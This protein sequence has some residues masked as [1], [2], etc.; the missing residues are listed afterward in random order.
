MP[1]ISNQS[2][3]NRTKQPFQSEVKKASWFPF[4]IET[5]ELNCL[6]AGNVHCE[7]CYEQRGEVTFGKR[8]FNWY[9]RMLVSI[10]RELCPVDYLTWSKRSACGKCF[11]ILKIPVNIVLKFT[12]PVVIRW[13]QPL[14]ALHCVTSPLFF[15]FVIG[16]GNYYIYEVIPIWALFFGI[17]VVLMIGVLVTTKWDEP[18]RYHMVFAVMG[19]IS[20]IIWVY[21]IANEIVGLLIALG[22]VF[23]ISD[24]ILGLTVLAWGNSINDVVSDVTIAREGYPEMGISACFGGPLFNLLMGLGVSFTTAIYHSQTKVFEVI[25]E[26]TTKIL[27]SFLFASLISS[28]V[29]VPCVKFD[30]KRWY[31]L[32]L[33]SLYAIFLVVI[34]LN[35]C[36]L[37]SNI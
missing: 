3:K 4:K 32:Y 16:Y 33:Y 19:F 13:C 10:I 26:R 22:G 2:L 31:G 27:I 35:E 30:L 9:N 8:V 23:N 17:G 21:I 28:L 36:G 34:T 18:P 1:Q 24:S 6:F 25:F 37:F 5:D 12:I 15:I 29:I 7:Y 14:N 20:S 11:Q